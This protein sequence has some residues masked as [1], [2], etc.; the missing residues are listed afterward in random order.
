MLKVGGSVHGPGP[1]HGDGEAVCLPWTSSSGAGQGRTQHGLVH[2]AV[3]AWSCRQSHHRVFHLPCT[4]GTRQSRSWGSQRAGWA[5]A[6][7]EVDVSSRHFTA[8]LFA[9]R[10]PSLGLTDPPLSLYGW[11]NNLM[12]GSCWEKLSFT[13]IKQIFFPSFLPF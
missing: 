3:G 1:A 13:A 7:S 8:G 11:Q 10:A 5:T 12:L 9:S 4:S 6:S 2:F